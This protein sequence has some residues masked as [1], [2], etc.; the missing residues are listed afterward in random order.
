MAYDEHL[1]NRFRLALEKLERVS[2]RRMMGGVCFM[3]NGNMLGGADRQ[4]DGKRRFMFR[5]GK[6]NQAKALE[7]PGAEIMEMGGKRMGGFCFV[8]AES[9]DDQALK[10]WIELALPFVQK[11]PSK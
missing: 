2:E 7:R 3:V 8:D 4:K 6:D 9:C 11:L 10:S 1:T 5:I